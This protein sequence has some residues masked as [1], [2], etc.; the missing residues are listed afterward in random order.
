[1]QRRGQ[2]AAIS[3]PC[4]KGMGSPRG[5]GECA[6]GHGE[7]PDGVRAHPRRVRW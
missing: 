3:R 2:P 7:L 1:M 6:H 4:G 5:D